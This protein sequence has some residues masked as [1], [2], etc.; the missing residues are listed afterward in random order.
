MSDIPEGWSIQSL[1]G[2]IEVL[3]GFPFKSAEFTDD[4]SK[5][6]LIR[7]RDLI[8]QELETFYTGDFDDLF[9]VEKG[10]ILIGMDGDF[11]IVKWKT[12]GAL[13]N[14]R[15]CKVKAIDGNGF[16]TDFLFHSLIIDLAEIH[17]ATGATTVKH[18]SVKDLR[19]IKK[20]YPPLP[21]QKKIASILSSVD[22]VIEKTQAHI[23]KLKDL[24][25]GLMQELLTKGI[26]HT[27]FKDS[28]VGRI[29]VGWECR[30]LDSVAKR[31]SGHTPD[32]QKPEYWNDGVKWVSLADSY[33][34]DQLYI[35]DSDKKISHLGIENSSAVIHPEGTVIMSRD[36]GIGKSA[37]TEDSMAVSQHFM[38]WVCC[39][40]LN[41]YFLYYLLQYWKPKFEA[42]AM[43]ST[44]K[45]IGLPYFKKLLIPLPS[46]SEQRVISDTLRSVDE[47]IFALQ[48]K[49]V[50]NEA[51]KKALMQDLLTGKVRVKV[52]AH[53]E[54]A[55]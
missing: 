1:D 4:K 54:P 11:N 45:T 22:E 27:E 53:H 34:L 52:D 42:I 12:K 3:S 50:H 6:G 23:D 15:I 18:L 9:L 19:G 29:P 24:K 39:E 14:Q 44:I 21:E 37:I 25:T 26:G 46:M 32:K 31:G 41:K 55:V 48:K 51:I 8:K 5:V 47:K 2:N 28:P 49:S 33:R 13:L 35:N 17:A 36:A 7:I 10:D 20:S 30:L 38:A 16:D 43:G 40:E